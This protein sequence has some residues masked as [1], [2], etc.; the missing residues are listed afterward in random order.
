MDESGPLAHLRRDRR[1]LHRRPRRLA[2]R[3]HTARLGRPR[4]RAPRIGRARLPL[5]QP[6][7][8]REGARPDRRRPD[9]GGRAPP[10]GSRRLLRGRQRHHPVRLRHRRPRPPLRRRLGAHHRDRRPRARLHRLRPGPHAPVDPPPARSHRL[11]Q[12]ADAGQRG[13]PRRHGGRPL[14]DDPADRPPHLGIRPSAP[15]RRG[16]PPRG[17][18]G[19]GVPRRAGRGRLARAPTR[20]RAHPVARP[21]AR[22]PA[23]DARV[24][25]AVRQGA[26]VGRDTG[27]GFFPK[28][29]EL[30]P[31]QSER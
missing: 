1:Q 8:A 4:R 15:H 9:P 20:G 6:G 26:A 24:G 3:R 22:G 5:R 18:A 28:R 23:L 14:G 11:L 10:T 27:D 17:A 12:R 19:A 30:L 29:P 21:A 2:P 13:A 16:P 7:R 31:V 25:A